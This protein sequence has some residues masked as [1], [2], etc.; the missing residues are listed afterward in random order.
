MGETPQHNDFDWLFDRWLSLMYEIPTHNNRYFLELVYPLNQ[1]RTD[2]LIICI[3][4]LE[5]LS[6]D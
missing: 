4:A 6:A 3:E 2:E 5:K 1:E